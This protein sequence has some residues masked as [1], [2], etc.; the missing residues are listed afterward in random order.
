MNRFLDWGDTAALRRAER[1]FEELSPRGDASPRLRGEDAARVRLYRGLAGF[2]LSYVASLRGH[3]FR[4]ATL[5]LAARDRLLSP[6]PLPDPEAR[7]SLMLY[8]YYRGRLL[9]RLPFVDAPEFPVAAFR[10]AA[11]ASPGAREMLLFSLFWVHVDVKRFDEASAITEDFLTRYP[12]NRLARELR[13]SLAFRRGNP[14]ESRAEY[15]K[16]REEYAEQAK[17]PG[18]IPLGY[19]RAVGNILRA[20]SAAGNRREVEALRKE[21]KRGLAGP[22]GPWLPAGLKEELSRL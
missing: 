9:E 3:S 11:D 13:G 2:Q 19:F 7:A 5:A 17:A 8:D 14:S 4:A 21:W 20:Q 15:E 22:A 6:S 1:R 10:K 12:G 18:R 16:L